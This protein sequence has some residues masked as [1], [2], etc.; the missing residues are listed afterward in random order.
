MM[1]TVWDFQMYQLRGRVGRSNR[2]AYAFLLYRRDK[3]LKEVAEKRLAAIRELT[4]LGSGFKIA[5][6]DVK[7]VGRKSSGCRNSMGIWRLFGYDKDAR[8]GKTV[9]RRNRGGNLYDRDGSECGCSYPEFLYSELNIR[10]WIF[11]GDQ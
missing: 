4:D 1:Q 11:S 7:S 5:M 3:L 2:M 8:S 9:K 10:S 6:R